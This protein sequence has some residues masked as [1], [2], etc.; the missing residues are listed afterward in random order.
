MAT[1]SYECHCG[2]RFDSLEPMPGQP[3]KVCP[4]CGGEAR[5]VIEPVSLVFRGSGFHDNDYDAYGPR[6]DGD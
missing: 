4:E 3:T 6:G 5:R 2:Y 1:Y